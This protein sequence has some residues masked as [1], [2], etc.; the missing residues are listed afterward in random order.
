VIL[1]GWFLSQEMKKGRV[2]FKIG[3]VTSLL[4]TSAVLSLPFLYSTENLHLSYKINPFKHNMGWQAIEKGLKEM[5]YN[6]DQHFLVSDKYQTASILSFYAQ[7]Q[8]RAYFLNLQGVRKNQFCY[9]PHLQK[10]R[11]GQTG[12]FVWIENAPH[13]QQQKEE[14]LVFY[15]K[16]LEKYFHTVE[17]MGT[18]PLFRSQHALVKGAAIFKCSNCSGHYP[19][20]SIR[21]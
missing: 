10:E 9:W 4:L 14:K 3:L 1:V 16:E 5:G 19:P 20:D 15:Q 7:D 12:F 17:F 11:L 21:Y 8:K 2:W 18:V 6:P 13:F